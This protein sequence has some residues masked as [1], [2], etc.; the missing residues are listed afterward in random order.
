ML[1][2]R[3]LYRNGT[4]IAPQAGQ[5]QAA[6]RRRG[7][8]AAA[9]LV[10][11]LFNL[12]RYFGART[13]RQ[14]SPSADQH[15]FHEATVSSNGE[16]GRTPPNAK[17]AAPDA[18]EILASIGEAFYLWDIGSDRLTW[19]ANVGDVLLV[20]DVE[21]IST[22]RGYAQILS[23]EN[24]QSRLDAVTASDQ[25]DEGSGRRLSHSMLHPSRPGRADNALGR[26]HRPLVR[27]ARRKAGARARDR[28]RHQRSLRAR[29]PSQLSRPLR[30]P[31]RRTKPAS[32][33]RSARKD[34]RG[35]HT[36][37]LL[38]RIS[39]PRHRRPGAHQRIARLRHR[40]SGDRRRRQAHSRP[41]AR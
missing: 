31:H 3:L 10:C 17:A 30:R 11:E 34:P 32:P 18:A 6:C 26:G 39:A 33:H 38:L 36:I 35:R 27:R 9:P 8:R 2:W 13:A 28:S 16:A 22:G 23:P 29:K 40:R 21:A 12:F 20:P 7:R 5:S 1:T 25:R 15:C 37:S 14:P 24:H 4:D 19:S 41:D